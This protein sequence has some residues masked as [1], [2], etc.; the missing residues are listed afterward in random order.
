MIRRESYM[1][2]KTLEGQLQ[3]KAYKYDKKKEEFSGLAGNNISIP[4]IG[5]KV[6]DDVADLLKTESML[7]GK[8]G[9]VGAD[10]GSSATATLGRNACHFPPESWLRWREYHEKARTLI[11]SATS[12][13][14]L[15]ELANQAIGMN[16]FGEHYLQDSFAAG[17]LIN[18][19]FVMAV[20]ME[21]MSAATK[22]IRGVT[23]EH[24]IELQT[25][26]AHKDAY[27]L[28]QAAQDKVEAKA[29]RANEPKNAMDDTKIKA[30]DPQSALDAA[31][32][33]KDA[34]AGPGAIKD[35]EML[36][37]GLDRFGMSFEQYRLF[38]NDF[39][40]QKITNTLHDKY[41]INGLTVASPD[42]P[43][44]FKIYGDNNMMR[45]SEGAAYTAATSLMSR[46]AINA[47]VNNKREALAASGPGGGEPAA[48]RLDVPSVSAIVARFPDRVID[49]DGTAMSLETWATGAPMRKK[50]AQVV[51]WRKGDTATG[52]VRLMSTGKQ[53]SSGLTKDH[54]AF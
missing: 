43:K 25:A 2:L 3:G 53:V 28:P 21:H 17:H 45:S 40:L 5:P 48:K 44:L 14:Q 20:A 36:A 54:G 10:A 7:K 50:I 29:S 27:Q 4:G 33:K 34:G 18:K 42:N 24:I 1:Y 8:D 12:A 6:S 15:G 13:E 46:G 51:H 41:C 38:L 37:S 19:G 52:L 9:D 11:D 16:A 49:D 39:W 26:T 32:V 35:A 23:D 22:W 47:L 30:R 31:R